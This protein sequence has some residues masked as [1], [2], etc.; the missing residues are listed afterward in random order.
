MLAGIIALGGV[1]IINHL[2]NSLVRMPS[3]LQASDQTAPPENKPEN[4]SESRQ[5]SPASPQPSSAPQEK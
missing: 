3:W 4:R 1:W 2:D 5:S